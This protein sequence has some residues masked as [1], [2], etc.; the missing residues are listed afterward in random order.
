MPSRFILKLLYE[1]VG[2]A[3]SASLADQDKVHAHFTNFVVL[4]GSGFARFRSS[5]DLNQSY[6]L[7]RKG[8]EKRYPGRGEFNEK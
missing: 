5:T 8:K 4:R 1:N 7:L 2:F 6:I 3:Y